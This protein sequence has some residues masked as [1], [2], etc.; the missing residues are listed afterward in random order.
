MSSFP[1][2]LI[3]F[4]LLLAKRR[5]PADVW[6]ALHETLPEESRVFPLGMR[7]R[8]ALF[9]GQRRS[10]AVRNMVRSLLLNIVEI[11][12]MALLR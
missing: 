7:V 3:V 10:S 11:S 1:K 12:Y 6:C 4:A 2:Q 5:V 9:P 8:S